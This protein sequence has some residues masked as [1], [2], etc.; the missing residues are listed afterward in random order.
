[1]KLSDIKVG[2]WLLPDDGF[3]CLEYGKEVQVETDGDDL[4]VKCSYG[5]HYLKDHLEGD[6][7]IDF[8]KIEK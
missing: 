1:M 3:R 4:F 2:D 5:N 7:F 8:T 6:K